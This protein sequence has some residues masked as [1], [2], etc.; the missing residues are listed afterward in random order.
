MILMTTI[1]T[2]KTIF[3]EKIKNIIVYKVLFSLFRFGHS[4]IG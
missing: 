1:K 4:L 2:L 3:I